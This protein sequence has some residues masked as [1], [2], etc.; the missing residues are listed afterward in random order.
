[1]NENKNDKK[2]NKKKRHSG[3]ALVK[4]DNNKLLCGGVPFGAPLWF[5]RCMA[6]FFVGVRVCAKWTVYF[7]PALADGMG[8]V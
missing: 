1:M 3:I 6:R 2:N 7:C 5:A 8:G 4:K